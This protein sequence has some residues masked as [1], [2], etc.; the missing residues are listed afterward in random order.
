MCI[1][2]WNPPTRRVRTVQASLAAEEMKAL[3]LERAEEIHTKMVTDQVK[4]QYLIFKNNKLPE[5]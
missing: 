5:Y 2:P 4:E 3:E 1:S